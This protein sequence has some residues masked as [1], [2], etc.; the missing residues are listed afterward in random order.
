MHWIRYTHVILLNSV[1]FAGST[2]LPKLLL[3]N[4]A[5]HEAG[6]RTVH[7]NAAADNTKTG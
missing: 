5:C 3:A 7:A 6:Y 4:H 1:I 2:Q